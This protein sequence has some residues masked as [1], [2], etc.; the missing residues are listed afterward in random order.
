MFECNPFSTKCYYYIVIEIDSNSLF[1]FII[2]NSDL[3][4]KEIQEF[5][6]KKIDNFFLLILNV[7]NSLYFR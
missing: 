4:L 6:N 5:F 2:S 1:V 3:K 7:M